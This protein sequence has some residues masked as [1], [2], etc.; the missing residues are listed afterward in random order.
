M[1]IVRKSHK[2]NTSKTRYE[3]AKQ[4]EAFISDLPSNFLHKY[5]KTKP[6]IAELRRLQNRSHLYGQ[7]LK[8]RFGSGGG[9]PL[10][11]VWKSKKICD[12]EYRWIDG[13]I[14]FLQ[15]LFTLIQNGWDYIEPELKQSIID[16]PNSEITLFF[17]VLKEDFD[18]EFLQAVNGFKLSAKQI[19]ADAKLVEDIC[20]GNRA[21]LTEQELK[22]RKEQNKKKGDTL[23][24]NG[25]ITTIL[26]ICLK[27]A[28]HDPVLKSKLEDLDRI[29][30][31]LA[32]LVIKASRKERDDNPPKIIRGV[33]WKDELLYEGVK[34]GFR[35]VTNLYQTI[36]Q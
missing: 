29:Y 22:Q 11:R 18:S 20:N 3:T 36:S 6:L 30:A 10:L 25:W 1:N 32:D 26:N 7:C 13:E 23:L 35:P 33:K 24:P 16:Y 17:E 14:S 21:N 4:I 12:F 8:A 27:Y 15:A 28:D 31:E 19:E 9:N 2:P 34:G 5:A